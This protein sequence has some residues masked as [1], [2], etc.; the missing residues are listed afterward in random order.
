MELV[1]LF[2][3]VTDEVT[4]RS[5]DCKAVILNIFLR[6]ACAFFSLQFEYEH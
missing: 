6:F 4:Q 1:K 5:I 3:Q 2:V